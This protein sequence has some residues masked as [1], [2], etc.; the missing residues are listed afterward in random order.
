MTNT[1]QNWETYTIIKV[2]QHISFYISVNIN[3]IIS[4]QY[5]NYMYMYKLILLILIATIIWL[6]V[7]LHYHLFEHTC[8]VLGS[9]ILFLNLL[10]LTQK[11]DL[12]LLIF[13]DKYRSFRMVGLEKRGVQRMAGKVVICE[14]GL[15]NRSFKG[16]CSESTR[17]FLVYHW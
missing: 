6:A 3:L 12:S 13:R 10:S 11:I 4:Y 15:W 8:I 1:L 14:L 16:K 9:M 5:H 17:K 7:K 2:I